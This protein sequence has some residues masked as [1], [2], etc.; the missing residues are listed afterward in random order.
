MVA[1]EDDNG[2]HEGH[3]VFLLQEGILVDGGGLCGLFL[4]GFF[5]LTHFVKLG[6]GLVGA[7]ATR[8]R[9]ESGLKFAFAIEPTRRIGDGEGSEGE[10]D[11]GDGAGPEDGAPG[12]VLGRKDVGGGAG[13][14]DGFNVLREVKSDQGGEDQANGEHELE[15]AR[16]EAALIRGETLRKIERDDHTDEAGGGTLKDTPGDQPAEPGGNADDRHAEHKADAGNDHQ[17]FAPKE[18]RQRTR[19]EG[20]ED[21][22]T[23]HGRNDG[24]KLGGG[25]VGGGL[26][27]GQ[28][29]GDDA[30][31]NAVEQ[32]AEAGD[33][34]EVFVV[35]PGSHGESSGSEMK[36]KKKA[37]RR[38]EPAAGRRGISTRGARRR[39]RTGRG[40]AP[41]HRA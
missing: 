18:V 21:G 4:G 8:Q 3:D 26:K 15:H 16:A 33:K 11:A 29:T 39:R 34:E 30:Y 35:K 25:I 38:G 31:V 32:A 27:I 5:G 24:G 9:G 12:E 41:A 28:R 10:D 6:L 14:G 1:G 13:L 19:K 20:G 23:Q 37:R 36:T 40:G 2:E 17:P 7:V 22:A